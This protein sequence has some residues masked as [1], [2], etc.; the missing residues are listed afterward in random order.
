VSAIGCE[1]AL[2]MDATLESAERELAR[3][4]DILH[5]ANEGL[6]AEAGDRARREGVAALQFHELCEQ[7]IKSAERRI[8]MVRVVLGTNV[9]THA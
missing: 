1:L 6:V 2:G 5:L 4:R 8:G 9:K 3:V 7:L